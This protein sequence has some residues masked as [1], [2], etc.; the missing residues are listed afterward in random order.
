MLSSSV[1]TACSQAIPIYDI[2]NSVHIQFSVIIYFK[3]RRLHGCNKDVSAD[4]ISLYHY[5]GIFRVQ[6]FGVQF[7]QSFLVTRM[8]QVMDTLDTPHSIRKLL[9]RDREAFRMIF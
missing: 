4:W 6:F 8:S 1:N 3:W 2:S 5:D 7:L 9:M